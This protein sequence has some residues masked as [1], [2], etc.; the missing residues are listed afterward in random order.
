[1]LFQLIK[2]FLENIFQILLYLF[3]I[4]FFFVFFNNM[5]TLLYINTFQFYVCTVN[6]S[7]VGGV[8]PVTVSLLVLCEDVC[9]A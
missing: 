7:L 4:K 3:K 5:V 6:L 1:M 2:F 8:C 9:V